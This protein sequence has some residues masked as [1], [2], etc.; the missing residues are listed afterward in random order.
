MAIYT[1]LPI[2]RA[3]YSLLLAFSRMLPDM[4]RDCRYSMGQDARQ[5][6]M[7][8]ILLVYRANR[9]RQKVPLI[10]RMRECLL[11]VQVYVR[12]MSDLKY[13]S[14][15]RYVELMELT[16]QMSRQMAAWQKSE[17]KKDNGVRRDDVD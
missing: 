6:M 13:I 17:A 10:S 7:D 12:L 2:Y 11:E 15:K 9:T 14:E 16:A 1:D 3:S 5:K 8:I 4:P